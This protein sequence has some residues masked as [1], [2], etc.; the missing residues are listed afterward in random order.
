MLSNICF[1][2]D[3][4]CCWIRVPLLAT[5]LPGVRFYL[6]PRVTSRTLLKCC[7]E[8]AKAN[9]PPR[10]RTISPVDVLLGQVDSQ[11]SDIVSPYPVTPHALLVYL[12]ECGHVNF[13]HQGVDYTTE[14]EAE[15]WALDKMRE[16]KIPLPLDAR[17]LAKRTIFGYL[18]KAILEGHSEIDSRAMNFLRTSKR[19]LLQFAEGRRQGFKYSLAQ[20]AGLPRREVRLSELDCDGRQ[21]DANPYCLR[22][23]PVERFSTKDFFASFERSDRLLG[24]SG[25]NVH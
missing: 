18:Q 8:C 4:R 21:E 2:H 5:T 10:V 11:M 17:W 19:R 6:A 12:H 1:V 7:W 9:T 14:I 23:P 20:F 16:A 3:R 13:G 25:A 24:V 22:Q 15:E